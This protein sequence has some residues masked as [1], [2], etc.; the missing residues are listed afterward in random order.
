MRDKSC[1]IK[2]LIALRTYAP[3]TLH[4]PYLLLQPCIPQLRESRLSLIQSSL[5]KTSMVHNWF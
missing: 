5:P 1:W 3:L 4:Q 2:L